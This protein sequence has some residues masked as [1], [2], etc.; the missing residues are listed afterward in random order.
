MS[1]LSRFL[2]YAAAFEQ[3]FADDNWGRLDP[4]F[5]ETAEYKVTGLPASCELI[6]RDAIF[7]GIRKSLDGF[8]RKM[9]SREIVASEPPTEEGDTVTL[10]GF[11]RYSRGAAPPIELHAV[12]VARFEGDRIAAMHDTF[13]LDGAA[14]KWLGANAADLDGSYV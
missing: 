14:M 8:D 9:T 11:V 3:T 2:E 4:F 1:K 13:T 6:G 12:I 10:K 5:T 7:R